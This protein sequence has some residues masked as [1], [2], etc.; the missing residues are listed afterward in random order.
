[1]FIIGGKRCHP[2]Y[3]CIVDSNEAL[4]RFP[5]ESGMV[6]G[7][8]FRSVF[9]CSKESVEGLV[10][11]GF[12]V[13]GGEVKFNSY[14]FNTTTKF[15]DSQN[16]MARETQRFIRYVVQEWKKGNSC[17]NYPLRNLMMPS[18]NSGW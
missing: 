4:R 17:Q 16:Q 12:A 15:H 5:R 9:G 14:S 2:G 13:M 10:G 3:V 18:Q 11:E 8:A 7:A 1:M 6:H